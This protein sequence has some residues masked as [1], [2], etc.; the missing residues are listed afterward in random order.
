MWII[1]MS[2]VQEVSIKGGCLNNNNVFPYQSLKKKKKSC[3][4]NLTRNKVLKDYTV[5]IVM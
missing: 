5:Y 2:F 3:S 4:T 1:Y